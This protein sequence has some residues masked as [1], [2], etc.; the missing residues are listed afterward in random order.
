MTLNH[1]HNYISGRVGG[2][3]FVF[4]VYI[5]E[6]RA[7]NVLYGTGYDVASSPGVGSGARRITSYPLGYPFDRQIYDYQIKGLTNIWFEDVQIYHKAD[8][9]M[10][11]PYFE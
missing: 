7:P 11:I 9:E 6:Y 5:G 3:P 10:N 8:P 1:I 2:M 4:A